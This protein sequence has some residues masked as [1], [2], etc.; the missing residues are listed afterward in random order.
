MSEPAAGP[1]GN[2]NPSSSPDVKPIAYNPK[3]AL[4]LLQKA[5]WKLTD[6]GLVKVIDGKETPFEFTLLTAN[7]DFEKYVTVIKEDM[8]K[9]GI[10]LNIKQLEWNS[11]IKLLDERKFDAV[12]L[13]WTAS[14]EPDPYQIW[15]SDSA[16]DTGSNFVS[17]S[18][19][20]V[21]R[22]IIALRKEMDVKKRLPML[23][24][25]HELIAEDQ[26]YSFLFNRKFYLYAVNARIHRPQDSLKFDTGASTWSVEQKPQP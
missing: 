19:P 3:G 1:F 25:V 5:G 22:L 4:E 13:G 20:E 21:D 14:V 18:N 15:H 12:N 11:F 26:P 9:V 6:K 2:S 7:P 23:H 16:K 8:H 24:R 10:T 17:Y